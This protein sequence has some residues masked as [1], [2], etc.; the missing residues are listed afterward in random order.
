MRQMRPSPAPTLL[1]S[2]LPISRRWERQTNSRALNGS[3]SEMLSVSVP[4]ACRDGSACWSN[5]IS[6][7]SGQG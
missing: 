6:S 7:V 4:K 5:I 1:Y 3:I 2:A